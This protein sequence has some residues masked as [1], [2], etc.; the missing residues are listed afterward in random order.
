VSLRPLSAN[1]LVRDLPKEATTKSGIV[2]PDTA[3]REDTAIVE[4]VAAGP[5]AEAVKPGDHV[6]VR[7][8]L[9]E[10]INLDGGK[11][12]ACEEDDVL[13]IVGEGHDA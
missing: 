11:Q 6:L 2:L 7:R 4:V 1:L 13:A 10:P 8:A 12:Y 9:L 5:A 3:E